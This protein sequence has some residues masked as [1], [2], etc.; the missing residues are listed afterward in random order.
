[1]NRKIKQLFPDIVC[2]FSILCFILSSTT[3]G[4]WSRI[5]DQEIELSLY[6]QDDTRDR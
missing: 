1:M 6:F 2:R 5:C 4:H 3:S